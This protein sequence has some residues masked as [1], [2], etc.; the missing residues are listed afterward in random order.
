MQTRGGE[1][2]SIGSTPPQQ[3]SK[4]DHGDHG[5]HF[6]RK[7]CGEGEENFLYFSKKVLQNLTTI[8]EEPS[9]EICN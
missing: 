3:S 6:G 9:F 5:H 4:Q 1:Y 7:T 2:E 8:E